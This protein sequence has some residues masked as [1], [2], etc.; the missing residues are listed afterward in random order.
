MKLWLPFL[1]LIGLG[2]VPGAAA[3]L[4]I[5]LISV[6]SLPPVLLGFLQ[7]GLRRELGVDVKVGENL[8][9]P[10]ACPE[11]RG[12]V[13]ASLFWPSWRPPGHPGRR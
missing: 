13:R 1:A 3:P 8:P 12:S 10:A 2:A 5:R 11:G 9:L 6:G 7:E 4:T